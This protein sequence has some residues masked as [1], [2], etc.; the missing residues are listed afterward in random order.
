MGG[1]ENRVDYYFYTDHFAGGLIP[2]DAFDRVIKKAENFVDYYT[3]GKAAKTTD[4]ATEKA[5]K[6]ACCAV[7][8]QFFVADTAKQAAAQSL[9]AV[10]AG[11]EIQSET[12]GSY[13]VTRR[14]GGESA[15]AMLS[16]ATEA[17]TAAAEAARQYLSGTGLLY[18][19]G[20]GRCTH[21]TL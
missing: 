21:H 1:C 19:G 18:R 20:C 16:A 9:S 3:S 5:I 15:K 12:V 6:M 10:S 13:S 17:K 8:E 11:G 7:A 4:A 2:P 14:S